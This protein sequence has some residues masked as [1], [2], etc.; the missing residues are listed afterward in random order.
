[1]ETDKRYFI[2]GLFIIGFSLAAALFAVWLVHTSHRDDVIY[3]IHFAESVSGLTVGD[4]V[5]FHGVEVGN[6]KVVELD[7]GNPKLV[8]VDVQLRRETPVK[9]DTKASLNLKGIT[10]VVYVELEGGSPGAGSLQATTPAGQIPEIPYERSRI[11]AIFDELPKVIQKFSSLEDQA[12]KVVTEVRGVTTQIKENP[13]VL[14][15]GP[16]KEAGA[17]TG[18]GATTGDKPKQKMSGP[19]AALGGPG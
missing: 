2:E 14:L 7:P 16:T 11:A 17:A 8:Q 4:P 9:T 10:G 5:K 12:R 13:S 15:K 6:V 19:R 18:A 1:M 3:R